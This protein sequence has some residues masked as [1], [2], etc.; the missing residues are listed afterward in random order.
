[1]KRLTLVLIALLGFDAAVWAQSRAYPPLTEYMMEAEVALAKS[2]AP[3]NIS[4]RATVKI[5]T[6][7]GYKVAVQ[8][9]SGFVCMVLRGWNGAPEPKLV[10]DSKLRAPLCFDPV[11]SRTVGPMTGRRGTNL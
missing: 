7:S 8:G 4:E 3:D 9:D 5:L 6:A 1:M 11:A 10:Y 2:A